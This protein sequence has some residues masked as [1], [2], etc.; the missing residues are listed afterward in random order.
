VGVGDPGDAS[1][2]TSGGSLATIRTP[3]TEVIGQYVKR[4]ADA[5]ERAYIPQD[6]KE[7]VRAYFTQLGK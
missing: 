7:Y 3:Y 2:G 6:A 5:L 4:A 1:G